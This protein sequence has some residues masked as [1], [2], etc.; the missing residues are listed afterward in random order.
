MWK[1]RKMNLVQHWE[2]E[3]LPLLLDREIKTGEYTA[4]QHWQYTS[5]IEVQTN[6]GRNGSFM[7]DTLH[8][9][10]NLNPNVLKDLKGKPEI[11]F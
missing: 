10:A 7:F 3:T 11:I 4:M 1:A 2:R 9:G 8:R 5:I 6:S